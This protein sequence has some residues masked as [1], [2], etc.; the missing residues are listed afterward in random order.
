[1]GEFNIVEE[2][3]IHD[4]LKKVGVVLI[5]K[6]DFINS[7]VNEDRVVG[8]RKVDDDIKVFVIGEEAMEKLEL[9]YKSFLDDFPDVKWYHQ[10]IGEELEIS[11]PENTDLLEKYEC[12]LTKKNMVENKNTNKSKRSVR[13]L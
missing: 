5:G 7:T 10:K 9:S 11:S 1:M 8:F 4:D 2:V 3:K 12:F 13:R 6:D